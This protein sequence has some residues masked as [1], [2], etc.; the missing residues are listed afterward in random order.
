MKT[1][2]LFLALV[3]AVIVGSSSA[4]TSAAA[5]K[6][7][8]VARFDQPVVLLGT[9]LQGE[10]LFVHDDA[11]MARGENCTFVYKGV[12]EDKDKLVLSFHCIPELRSKVSSFTFRT[13]LTPAGITELREIQFEGS[14]EAHLVPPN[15]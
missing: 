10:Y 14:T 3:C 15:K 2:L 9:T 7:R 13:S 5:K 1:V 11:A 12:S 6:D 8:A 4:S